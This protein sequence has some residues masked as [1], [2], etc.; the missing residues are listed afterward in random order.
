M[1]KYYDRNQLKIHP[2]DQPAIQAALLSQGALWAQYGPLWEAGSG[3]I[4]VEAW[5]GLVPPPGYLG[6]FTT[7][8]KSPNLDQT[9]FNNF[10]KRTI[11]GGPATK[12]EVD[13]T[14]VV[15]G[16]DKVITSSR[17]AERTNNPTFL[18]R[19]WLKGYDDDSMYSGYSKNEALHLRDAWSGE[20]FT[21]DGTKIDKSKTDD[22]ET[23]KEEQAQSL[24]ELIAYMIWDNSYAQK[25]PIFQLLPLDNRSITATSKELRHY[26]GWHK[27][28]SIKDF[29]DLLL[30]L[31]LNGDNSRRDTL[32]KEDELKKEAGISN[33][34]NPFRTLE[35]TVNAL[36]SKFAT[37]LSRKTG[38]SPD[39]HETLQAL[40]AKNDDFFE[41][42]LRETTQCLLRL[43]IGQF[44]SARHN[45]DLRK[46]LIE[47]GDGY[48]KVPEKS[49]FSDYSK[50]PG[51]INKLA[52]ST[53]APSFL[54][55]TSEDISN[56]V[57]RI[58]LFKTYQ[59]EDAKTEFEVEFPFD[60]GIENPL[61]ARTGVG[62]KSFD[63]EL[64]GDNPATTRNDIKA[65]LTLYFQNFEDLLSRRD[66]RDII[67]GEIIEQEIS[68]EHLLI[69]PPIYPKAS[70]VSKKPSP[71][72][73]KCERS[74]K[75]FE[76]KYYE[77]KALVGWSPNLSL[78]KPLKESVDNQQI[79]LF[80]TLIDHE[81]N[82][83]QEGTFEL[84]ITYRARMESVVMDPK[85]DI[86]STG[87][88][89][90]KMHD[91][92]ER[93]KDLRK[94][95]GSSEQISAREREF[96]RLK[97][98]GRDTLASNIINGLKDKIYVAT[99][100]HGQFLEAV[101]DLHSVD[102]RRP[103]R[104]T[105]WLSPKSIVDSIRTRDGSLS[106]KINARNRSILIDGVS[107]SHPAYDQKEADER[108]AED[109]TSGL[110]PLQFVGG[111][112]QIR[113]P[114]KLAIPWFYFGDLVGVVVKYCKNPKTKYTPTSTTII[115][116]QELENILFLFNSFPI[117]G[118]KQTGDPLTLHINILDVP[119][120]VEMF[121]L[122]FL[123]NV[124]EADKASYPLLEFLRDFVDTVVI[125]SINK[126]C[127]QSEGFKTYW[128]QQTGELGGRWLPYWWEIPTIISKT[129][130]IPIA[131][132]ATSK[133]VSTSNALVAKPTLGANPFKNLVE[134][135]PRPWPATTKPAS[136]EI[137]S[138]WINLDK[139]KYDEDGIR[140][141]TG[142][143]FSTQRNLAMAQTLKN[144]YH[145]M[146]FYF[147]TDDGYEQFGPPDPDEPRQKRDA[148]D[149]V[150][151]LHLGRDRGL[152]K[153]VSFSKNDSPYLR[154]ARIQQDSLNPLAQLAATYNVDLKMVGNTIF[155]PG[156]YVFVNPSGFGA[157]LG[158]PDQPNSVANQLGLGGYHRIINV[159][160]F[161]E[162]GKFETSIQALFEFS[163]DG[164]P[165]LPGATPRDCYSDTPK[166]SAT[167]VTEP[168]TPT[169]DAA[170]PPTR[171]HG[172]NL[173][174]SPEE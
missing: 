42:M 159:K 74:N 147:I 135:R 97:E 98:A 153:S 107:P 113:K 54:N 46:E 140:T 76:P 137:G 62:I 61:D 20:S 96:S 40:A 71:G 22:E 47:R 164:C 142:P 172:G 28:L 81:F 26:K 35:G 128:L 139:V 119:I 89:K 19:A 82:F 31:Y 43:N 68:Y 156:Q 151:H 1:G 41:G 100:P 109:T 94:T 15:G 143:Q 95:C 37:K 60:G 21:D 34:E 49:V 122:W 24:F 36:K 9:N 161:I 150:W 120:T 138:N 131:S 167:V 29:Q 166:G 87:H 118:Y 8:I 88:Q 80:L 125:P 133:S 44:Y 173:G 146:V 171:T 23:T 70:P 123:Q 13:T 4:L 111:K 115:P 170:S 52:N 10:F 124:I 78:D 11:G 130:N 144:S 158:H 112:K 17:S 27:D 163:G 18:S 92:E 90:E 48:F 51:F 12:Y 106:R 85:M 154:E 67:S 145:V 5:Q 129:T 136:D 102:G 121:N 16:G 33:N 169:N 168:T 103:P 104:N 108:N 50:N 30:Y 134:R 58:R 162:D 6:Q 3:H 93:I 79:P 65:T 117:A 77:I 73:D 99:V 110:F 152:V 114:L 64:I 91:I 57:P 155:W 59:D 14:V 2:E 160:N 38:L 83:T 149:G 141:S 56:L 25:V 84:K 39:D 126:K 72:G 127:F 75:L 53:G 66:G 32:A 55:I 157:K 69:R 116:S 148:E 45:E 165:S 7:G 86:L 63:W 132:M 105:L 101:A 174:V